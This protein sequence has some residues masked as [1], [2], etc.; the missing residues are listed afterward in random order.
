MALDVPSIP[1]T[2][3]FPRATLTPHPRLPLLSWAPRGLGTMVT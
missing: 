3:L 2:W 1:V